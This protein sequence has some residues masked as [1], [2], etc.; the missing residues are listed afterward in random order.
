MN[1]FLL[2][3]FILKHFKFIFVKFYFL[4]SVFVRIYQNK[5]FLTVIGDKNNWMCFFIITLYFE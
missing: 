3:D 2:D 4:A 5:R 1:S